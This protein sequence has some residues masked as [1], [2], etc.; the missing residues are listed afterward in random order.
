MYDAIF[1]YGLGVFLAWVTLYPARYL[2]ASVEPKYFRTIITIV[3]LGFIGFPL[4]DGDLTG[5]L[6]ELVALV[7]LLVAIFLSRKVGLTLLAAVYFAHGAWDLTHVLGLVPVDKPLWVTRLC[8]PYDWILAGY[9]V[10]RARSR[11]HE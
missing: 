11:K 8:V 3:V 10:V 9:L 7:V 5:T 6:Y 1:P 2:D 4:A